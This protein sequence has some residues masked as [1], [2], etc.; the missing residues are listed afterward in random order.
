MVT[1]IKTWNPSEIMGDII[2]EV[3]FPQDP[4]FPRFKRRDDMGEEPH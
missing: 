4:P 2:G 1:E 3:L